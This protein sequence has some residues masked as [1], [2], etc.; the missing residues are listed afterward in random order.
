MSLFLGF[1]AGVTHSISIECHHLPALR[2][3]EAE[4]ACDEEDK[5][6]HR[7][8]CWIALRVTGGPK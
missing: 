4:G 7:E 2:V 1:P 5:Q 6:S 8:P 3:P